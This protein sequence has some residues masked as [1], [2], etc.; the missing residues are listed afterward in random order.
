MIEHLARRIHE[1]DPSRPV[2]SCIEHEEY[3]L[4]GELVAFRDEAPS[5]DVMGVNSYYR[6]QISH[7]NHVA[8][9]FD[10]L[11]PYLISEFGPEGY[12]DPKYNRTV[13]GSLAEQSDVEK[14]AWYRE[15]WK[16][17]VLA[18]KGYNVGGFAY[19]WHDRMEGSLTWFGLTDFEGRPKPAY[20]ALKSEWTHVGAPE[21]PQYTI[22]GH[23]QLLPGNTYTLYAQGPGL[24]DKHIERRL[25]KD[26]YLDEI[27]CIEELDRNG[28]IEITIPEEPSSYRLYMHVSDQE[29]TWVTTASIPVKVKATKN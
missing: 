25:L 16:H 6:Q 15:Q 24:E 28:Q 26:E 14:A 9:Q 5:V 19:C 10:S 8:W 17:Y 13:K 22:A 3:Q 20:F 7:L 12:W 2:F 23:R 21:I 1:L 4:G 11:R 18:Y 29:K 27:G